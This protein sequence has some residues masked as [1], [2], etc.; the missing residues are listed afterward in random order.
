[1]VCTL[2]VYG[3]VWY[4]RYPVVAFFTACV[5]LA[6]KVCKGYQLNILNTVHIV[7]RKKSNQVRGYWPDPVYRGEGY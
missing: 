6:C 4:V 7:W 2:S 5:R 1:M 3:K